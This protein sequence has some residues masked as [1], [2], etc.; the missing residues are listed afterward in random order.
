MQSRANYES[1]FETRLAT[2]QKTNI[3]QSIKAVCD[4]KISALLLLVWC[5]RTKPTQ[6]AKLGVTFTSVIFIFRV[7]LFCKNHDLNEMMVL[8]GEWI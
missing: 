7:V 2:V 1:N 5:P 6:K 4:A 8:K 3:R